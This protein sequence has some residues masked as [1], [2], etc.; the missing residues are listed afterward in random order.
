MKSKITGQCLS[1]DYSGTV[2]FWKVSCGFRRIFLAFLPYDQN[3]LYVI[4]RVCAEGVAESSNLCFLFIF[5]K[6]VRSAHVYLMAKIGHVWHA[7]D[8]VWGIKSGGKCNFCL[9]SGDIKPTVLPKSWTQNEEKRAIFRQHMLYIL[10]TTTE[11]FLAID[12]NS[13]AHWKVCKVCKVCR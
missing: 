10:S 8:G 1:P 7:H 5:R 12:R 2:Y 6:R 11:D 13:C 4:Q 3:L 9:E